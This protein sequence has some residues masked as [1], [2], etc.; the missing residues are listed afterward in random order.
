MNIKKISEIVGQKLLPNEAK[1]DLIIMVIADDKEAIGD[2]LKILATERRQSK[3]LII[4]MNLELSR[5]HCYIDERPETSKELKQQFNK[6]FIM[7]EIAKF[8]IKYKGRVTHCFNRF[9]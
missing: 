1:R 7:D 5:A 9:I 8:Y 6:S 4:D 2:I 3:E